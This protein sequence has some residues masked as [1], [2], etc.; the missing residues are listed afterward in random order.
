M[1]RASGSVTC[2][3]VGAVASDMT[4]VSLNVVTI[5]TPPVYWWSH[6]VLSLWVIFLD[7]YASSSM[8]ATV[9]SS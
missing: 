5:L 4:K 3:V 6:A 8:A 9:T 2:N 1:P 7:F